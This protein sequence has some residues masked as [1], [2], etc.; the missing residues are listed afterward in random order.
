MSARRDLADNIDAIDAQI[1]ELQGEKKTF[2]AAFRE[3]YGR[4]ECKAAQVAI[5]RRQKFHAGLGAEL[6]AHD[7]LADA[8]FVEITASRAPR[9]TRVRE[10]TPPHDPD[11]GE[12]IETRAAA[13]G[14][15]GSTAESREGGRVTS[16]LP[17]ASAPAA[18]QSGEPSSETAVS[19][20]SKPDATPAGA[21]VAERSGATA[22]ETAPNSELL[23]DGCKAG[24]PAERHNGHEGGESRIGALPEHGSVND[25]PA[26][27]KSV[28]PAFHSSDGRKPYPLDERGLEHAGDIPE[29]L[30]RA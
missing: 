11:T 6:E 27:V 24:S 20:S 5:K 10:T 29:S 13:D 9:A 1:A 21:V 28:Q 19:N 2:F 12:I 18:P 14:A 4:A 26:D 23:T 25:P 17:E 3:A 16:A 7:E 22:G 15:P 8:I 30:R